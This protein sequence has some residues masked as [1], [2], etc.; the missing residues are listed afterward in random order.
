MDFAALDQAGKK[1]GTFYPIVCAFFCLL[2]WVIHILT[3][4]RRKLLVRRVEEFQLRLIGVEA[5]A[6]NLVG[7]V[8][9]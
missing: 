8:L 4:V 3:H 9:R 5:F 7:E 1:P 6:A 2:T